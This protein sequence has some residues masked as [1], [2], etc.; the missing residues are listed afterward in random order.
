MF[1]GLKELEKSIQGSRGAESIEHHV[2]MCIRMHVDLCMVQLDARK[3]ACLIDVRIGMEECMWYSM[4][5][6]K[7]L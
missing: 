2:I 3:K 4:N 5:E 7:D 6:H 1:M